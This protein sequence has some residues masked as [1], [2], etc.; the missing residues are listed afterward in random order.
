MP[1]AGELQAATSM[2]S[3]M[4]ARPRRKCDVLTAPAKAFSAAATTAGF[5]RLKAVLAVH[6]TVPSGLEWNCGLL[7]APGADDTRTLRRTALVSATAA[8]ARL[9]VLLGLAACF[10]ALGRRIAALTEELLILSGKRE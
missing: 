7:P 10:A 1:R 9:F 8:A 3:K 2:T 6:G 4:T 5:A